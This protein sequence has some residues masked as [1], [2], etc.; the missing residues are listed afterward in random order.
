MP[1]PILITQSLDH[2]TPVLHK[3]YTTYIPQIKNPN[4]FFLILNARYATSSF[5]LKCLLLKSCLLDFRCEVYFCGQ[6]AAV[7]GFLAGACVYVLVVRKKVFEWKLKI[8]NGEGVLPAARFPQAHASASTTVRFSVVARSHVHWPAGRA[9]GVSWLA[10]LIF[11]GCFF[12]LAM[13]G[14]I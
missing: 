9:P 10:F 5:V 11:L 3:P 7:G 2:P 4:F 12:S 1:M 14:E 6:N 13:F 8:E